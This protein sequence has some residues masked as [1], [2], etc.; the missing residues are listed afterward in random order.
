[1]LIFRLTRKRSVRAYFVALIFILFVVL[2]SLVPGSFVLSRASSN[3]N[4]YLPDL[5]PSPSVVQGTA[6]ASL[7]V[8]VTNPV[9]NAYSITSIIVN[10]P[11]GWN[12]AGAP[13]CGPDLSTLG[14]SSSSI[15]QCKSVSGLPSGSSTTLELGTLSGPGSLASSSPV[16]GTFTTLITDASGA[17]SYAGNSFS[18]LDIAPTTIAVSITS[19]SNAYVAG[20]SPLEITMK[21]SSGQ[22][23]VPILWSF[24]NSLYPTQGYNATLA[25]S[26]S[27]TASNGSASTMFSPSDHAGDSSSVVATI[28]ESSVS[29][30]TSVITTLAGAPS[31]AIFS[32]V[33]GGNSYGIDYL[34]NHYSVGGGYYATTQSEVYLS[35]SDS[36]GNA[37][38]FSPAIKNITIAAGGGQMLIGDSFYPEVS[39]GTTSYQIS[40]AVCQSGASLRF[41]L[42]TIG[43]DSVSYIQSATYGTE[44]NLTATVELS[45]GTTFSNTS[46]SIVT[47]TFDNSAPAPVVNDTL[48]G[49]GLSVSVS[50]SL[51]A[52]E[53]VPVTF[54]LCTACTGTTPGYGATFLNGQ[55]SITLLTNSSGGV[56][57]AMPVNVT[58]GD[59][60]VFYATVAAPLIQS[61]SNSLTSADSATVTTVVGPIA[62][63][64]INIAANSGPASGPNSFSR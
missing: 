44:G 23:D 27:L 22:A 32:F 60:A 7:E 58:L 11:T 43:G 33:S 1:M 61:P 38:E 19:G 49:A 30:T 6:A 36:Y 28:G 41:P 35:L 21:L 4:A 25:P 39:C 52:Q 42:T 64:A 26:S 3:S 47:S 55:E 14:T 13:S 48:L 10:A 53:G 54:Y 29:S 56:S 12:F 24:S 51:Y 46:G 50:E 18:E 8:E 2:N 62:S 63:I 15:V 9:G 59:S 34:N 5:A 17:G 57:A 31:Q 16:Q 37:V 45:G 40:L 20:S